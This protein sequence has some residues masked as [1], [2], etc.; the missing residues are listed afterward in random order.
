VGEFG[1]VVA[2]GQGGQHGNVDHSGEF[3]SA[4]ADLSGSDVQELFD[5]GAPLFGQGFA[6]DEDE[7]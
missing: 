7:G 2:S 4:A 6:V 5:T 1:D 3:M